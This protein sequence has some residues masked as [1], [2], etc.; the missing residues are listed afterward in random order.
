MAS[1]FEFAIIDKQT[2]NIVVKTEPLGTH[3]IISQ[4]VKRLRDKGVG[5]FRTENHVAAD[6]QSAL[7]ELIFELK[8]KVQPPEV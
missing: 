7:E 2:G 6:A 3:D 4:F 5:F 1:R 8:A